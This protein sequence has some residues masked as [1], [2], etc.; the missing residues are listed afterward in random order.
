MYFVTPVKCIFLKSHPCTAHTLT[1]NMIATSNSKLHVRRYVAM[2]GVEKEH[3]IITL[4]IYHTSILRQ[5]N[6]YVYYIVELQNIVL[7]A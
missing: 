4:Q 7:C 6:E 1:T 3:F 5:W 2:I